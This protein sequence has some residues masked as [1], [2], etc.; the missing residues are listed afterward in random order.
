MTTT[1]PSVDPTPLA[2]LSTT[3]PA[4]LLPME[5]PN[6]AQFFSNQPATLFSAATLPSILPTGWSTPQ[7]IIAT[8][9]VLVLLATAVALLKL[10]AH[11][12]EHHAKITARNS[13]GYSASIAD[14][15]A[16]TSPK[17]KN[18]RLALPVNTNTPGQV[19][20]QHK[21]KSHTAHS[22]TQHYNVAS[23]VSVTDPVDTAY[24]QLPR[25]VQPV[26][27][28]SGKSNESATLYELSSK[29]LMMQQ[30]H[31]T[32]T[33]NSN[34]NSANCVLNKDETN[35]NSIIIFQNMTK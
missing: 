24:Y 20:A 25:Y 22:K 28:G 6:A 14:P 5:G 30:Q 31:N 26:S 16:P 3:P 13:V 9:F 27:E 32:F 19:Q 35:T 18:P 8:L 23:P 12:R 7:T 2:W 1:P 15:A 29:S 33:N 34:N 21:H 4:T 11:M 17:P 10:R